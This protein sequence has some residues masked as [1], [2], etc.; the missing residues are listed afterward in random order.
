MVGD[1]LYFFSFTVS[2]AMEWSIKKKK[3]KKKKDLYAALYIPVLAI[4]GENQRF[5]LMQIIYAIS[6]QRKIMG[7]YLFLVD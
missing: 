1:V 3:K 7:M 4:L 6:Q 2:G 5:H